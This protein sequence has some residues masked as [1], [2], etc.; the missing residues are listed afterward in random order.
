M[1]FSLASILALLPALALAHPLGHSHG[2]RQVSTQVVS[3]CNKPNQVALTFD[4][5][6]W[7]QE[8]AVA[9]KIRA[10]GG[11]GTFFVCGNLYSCIYDHADEMR[12]LYLQ[13][14][15]FASHTWSH[16]DDFASRSEADINSELEKVET[17]FRKILGVKPKYMRP[18]HGIYSDTL[19][20]V[21]SQRGYTKLWYWTD[22]MGDY[23]HDLGWQ[24]WRMDVVTASSPNPAN[25][26]LHSVRP[27]A[28]DMAQ[29][30]AEQ[31]TAK[32]YKLVTVDE[33]GGGG[34]AY[35]VVGAPQTRDATWTCGGPPINA[36][37][38]AAN[39]PPKT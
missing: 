38:V 11:R 6:F 8:T 35:Q 28:V 4:D 12:R 1:L 18:P 22:D 26:L 31:F 24:K 37:Y 34:G 9:D 39:P 23:D 19:L 10:K 3:N 13:G 14:H 15:L 16:Y 30:G 20:K 27:T 2:E 36:A 17:A 21:L 32:G 7:Y 29:Y 5:G 25:I 33:C